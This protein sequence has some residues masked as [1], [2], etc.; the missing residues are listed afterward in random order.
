MTI[1]NCPVCGGDHFGSVACP[2]IPA[3]CVVCGEQTVMA[4]SDCAIESGGRRSVHVC[5]KRECRDHHEAAH[6]PPRAEKTTPVRE[7]WEW[8]EKLV[9]DDTPRSEDHA[10]S[11]RRWTF[12]RNQDGTITMLCL[13]DTP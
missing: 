9:A 8:L 2:Y 4:C 3:P 12:T 1:R 5:A 10:I 7:Y 13:E 11:G 6:H